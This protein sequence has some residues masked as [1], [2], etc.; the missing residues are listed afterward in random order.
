MKIKLIIYG[1]QKRNMP[2]YFKNHL[3][4]SVLGYKH[5]FKFIQEHF[6]KNL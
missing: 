3:E 5:C 1:S 6:N 2:E 4:L